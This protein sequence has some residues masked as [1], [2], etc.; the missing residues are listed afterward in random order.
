MRI[1]WW[2]QPSTGRSSTAAA[3]ST[4]TFEPRASRYVPDADGAQPL[5]AWKRIDALQDAL[6]PA[7]QGRA[8]AEGG[9]IDGAEYAERHA[10][11]PTLRLDQRPKRACLPYVAEQLTKQFRTSRRVG[12]TVHCRRRHRL[13]DRTRRDVLSARSQRCRQELDHEDGEHRQ[14][15]HVGHAH[16]ARPRSSGD[17]PTIRTAHGRRA[18]G[19]P[20]RRRAHGVSRTSSSTPGT[21]GSAGVAAR[22]KATE[23][24]DFAQLTE[25]ET[26]RSIR[27]R[28]A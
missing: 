20:A 5:A 17:G 10:P 11:G 28:A 8:A 27:S 15:G 9:T 14:P 4:S 25:R 24:L 2:W 13:P 22:A 1:S 21:S 3:T 16:G 23:L 6:P 26:T 12:L 7:D 19:R 18:P